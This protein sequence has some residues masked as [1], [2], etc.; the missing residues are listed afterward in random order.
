MLNYES[1]L[2]APFKAVASAN[3]LQK[4]V[5]ECRHILGLVNRMEKT[6][7]YANVMIAEDRSSDHGETLQERLEV[8][9]A[10]ISTCQSPVLYVCIQ[11]VSH[12]DFSVSMQRNEVKNPCF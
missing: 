1:P 12:A 11:R 8:G 3:N 2:V 9:S 4:T 6:V 7:Q 10:S 5:E